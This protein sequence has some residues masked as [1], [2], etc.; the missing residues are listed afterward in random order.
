MGAYRF[1][2]KPRPDEKDLARWCVDQIRQWGGVL[3]H[4]SASTLWPDKGLPEPGERDAWG[5]FTIAAPQFWWGHLADKPTRFYV[6]GIEPRN[7]PAIPLKLGEAERTQSSMTKKKL[8]IP[9]AKPELLKK[10]REK[11]P[12]ALAHWLVELARRCKP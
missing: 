3:E 8:A 4:P 6:V 2:A 7:L 5:G 12:P 10:D 9:G 11:T 1:I